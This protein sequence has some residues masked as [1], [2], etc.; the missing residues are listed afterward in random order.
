MNADADKR[1][2]SYRSIFLLWSGWAIGPLAWML[3]LTLVYLL[4]P[5]ACE[6][7]S[8]LPLYLATAGT[9]A[10]AVAG[11]VLNWHLWAQSGRHWPDEAHGP[12]PRSR[13]MSMIGLLGS[14]LF[15]VVIVAQTIPIVI[16]G[17]CG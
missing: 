10:L 6:W 4:A 13:F 5:L 2:S 16:L 15:V 7:E 17:A 11:L 8:G 12:E 14:A 1:L 9:L 3:H